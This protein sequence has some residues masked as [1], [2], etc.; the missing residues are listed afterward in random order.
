MTT[1]PKTEKPTTTTTT[2][3]SPPTPSPP[4]P[5]KDGTTRGSADARIHIEVEDVGLALSTVLIAGGSVLGFLLF[6]G[7]VAAV[8][9]CLG[10]P[11][12]GGNRV[13]PKPR[14]VRPRRWPD[15]YWHAYYSY[16]TRSM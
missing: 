16:G 5:T 4:A 14:H 15:H 12:S 13:H 3:A 6:V 10:G 2:T 1:P 11:Q 8:C 9:C 7:L